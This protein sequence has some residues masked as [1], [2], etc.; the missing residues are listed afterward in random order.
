M[1]DDFKVQKKNCR[2]I[3][4]KYISNKSLKGNNIYTI[5]IPTLVILQISHIEC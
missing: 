3:T 5:T 2:N 4:V 1:H